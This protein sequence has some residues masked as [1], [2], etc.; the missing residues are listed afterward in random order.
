MDSIDRRKSVRHYKI[1]FLDA[2]KI[3][4]ILRIL[5]EEQI[6]PSG[7][8][9]RFEFIA[10]NLDQDIKKI[11]TYG[12]MSGRYGAIVAWVDDN[13]YA[14][15]DYGYLMEKIA[16]R[17]VEIGIGTCWLGGSFSKRSIIEAMEI[18]QS[19]EK[20]I[21]SILAV[22]YEEEGRS[23]RELIISKTKRKRKDF[24][25]FFF[26]G[27]LTPI[28]DEEQKDI[29]EGVRWAPSAMNRQPVRIVWDGERVHF[30]LVDVTTSLRY[31]D[32]GVAMCHFEERAHEHGIEGKWMVDEQ[33]TLTNWIYLYSFIIEKRKNK[34]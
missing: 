13:K 8:R 6:G 7:Y 14:Y 24:N 22:G 26:T 27:A 9:L 28:V 33:A 16:L 25:E 15:I 1:K 23:I 34:Q 21:P 12:F 19:D 30:Y 4:E 20:N 5:D 2:D 31:L 17:L 11:V 29:L 10:E 32:M 3:S 18:D